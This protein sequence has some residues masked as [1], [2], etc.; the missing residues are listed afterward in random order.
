[1]ITTLS[2]IPAPA[3][4]RGTGRYAL[5]MDMSIREKAPGNGYLAERAPGLFLM[6]ITISIIIVFISV[7]L[8]G[9]LGYEYQR[10]GS[11]DPR[12]SAPAKRVLGPRGAWFFSRQRFQEL[13]K[14]CCSD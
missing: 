10:K 13:F 3:A 5:P 14:L 4:A 9:L 1:M 8:L 6:T 12:N 7:L 2:P 11:G